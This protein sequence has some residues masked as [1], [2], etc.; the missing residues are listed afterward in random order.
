MNESFNY[1]FAADARVSQVA[2]KIQRPMLYETVVL[3]A[4]VLRLLAGAIQRVFLVGS[5]LV[6]V[7]DN[8]VGRILEEMDYRREADLAKHFGNLYRSD[9]VEVPRIFDSYCTSKVPLEH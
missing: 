7:A 2:V 6:G 1:P 9:E 4:H 8:V 3:D 5:D